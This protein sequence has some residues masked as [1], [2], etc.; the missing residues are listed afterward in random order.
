MS[1]PV[2]AS[3][4]V[5]LA[6]DGVPI[7]GFAPDSFITFTR[8]ADITD[9]EVGA[10]AQVAIS[11]LP[12][13]TGTATI[14]LQQQTLSNHFLAGVMQKQE[15]TNQFVTGN[16]TVTDPSGSILG[17]LYSCHLKTAPEVDLG[18]SATGKTR[19]WVFFCKE[20]VFTDYL[21]GDVLIAESQSFIDSQ[22][23]DIFSRIV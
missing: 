18:S 21:G 6:W 9:E 12:D 11:R 4:D 7:T 20:L 19:A 23:S 1:L 16:L 15:Q 13:K 3:R 8:N 14:S 10:D 2:Y 5:Q 22:I 17:Q